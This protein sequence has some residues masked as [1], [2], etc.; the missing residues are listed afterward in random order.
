MSKKKKNNPHQVS[1]TAKHKSK[2]NQNN[3]ASNKKL[4][5]ALAGILVLTLVSYWPSLSN[6][7]VNLDDDRYIETNQMIRH[8]D[9]KVLFT[10]FWMGNY[11]PLVMMVY[12][13]IYSF[14][15]LEPKAYHTVNLI[16]H[17]INTSL[18]LFVILELTDVFEIAVVVSL[19]FGIH[20]IHV[21]SVAWVSE[22]KDLMYTCFF[23]S[24]LF[25]YLKYL[26]N[27]FNKKYFLFSL[28]FFLCSLFS[29]GVGV[30]LTIVLLLVDYFK[31]RKMEGKV[32]IEKIPFFILSFIFGV[33]AIKAQQDLGAIQDA[34]FSFPQRIVFACYGFTTYI[35][36]IIIPINLSAYYPYPAKTGE[37]IPGVYY[38]YP[39]IVIALLAGVFYSFKKTNK[40]F[41]SIGFYA[42]TVA[43]V[44]QLLPVGGAVIADRYSYIPSI[45]IFLLFAFGLFE[46]Y[47][48]SSY[49]TI[50]TA[51]LL[52]MTASYSF[53]TYQRTQVWKDGMTLWSDVINKG[54]EV[55]LAYNN[56]GVLYKQAGELEKAMK[57]Y[58]HSLSL[59]P[60]N[61]D[62]WSNIGLIFWQQGLQNKNLQQVYN[63][64]AM[65]YLNKAITL[66]PK[67]ATAYSNRGSVR[68]T[69]GDNQGALEDYTKAID[70]DM[71]FADP[72]YNRGI[73]YYNLGRKG[74]ACN[75]LN[76]AAQLGHNIAPNAVRDLCK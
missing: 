52:V 4:W 43:L 49:K 13:W 30:S 76:K 36:K 61:T 22:L 70:F 18:V 7:F 33:V 53:M 11:H 21:E 55:A 15:Q 16:L 59:S 67:F 75:D 73:V 32:F 29:K 71:N 26:K 37:S 46:L 24:S 65:K 23:L 38:G 48:N 19:L 47:K 31:G 28:L 25:W 57:D 56:R 51:L 45:G 72:Y 39:V 40:V 10:S 12:T 74:E 44:L 60:D 50:A 63:D 9:L 42:I 2:R 54:N 62:T 14:V 41:F 58:K 68:S 27:D 6:G 66:D 69:M 64:T 8:F 20:P 3:F 34:I 5:Y 17:L 35:L 1:D